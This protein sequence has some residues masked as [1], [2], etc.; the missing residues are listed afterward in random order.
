MPY[1]RSVGNAD[2]R[3]QNR[4]YRTQRNHWLNGVQSPIRSKGR[5][6]RDIRFGNIGIEYY[7]AGLLRSGNV[8]Y[9]GKQRCGTDGCRFQS[10]CSGRRCAGNGYP[11]RRH[12]KR[13]EA[14]AQ[15]RRGK[16]KNRSCAHCQSCAQKYRDMTQAGA[17]LSPRMRHDFIQYS[18]SPPGRNRTSILAL[19]E[20]CS[21][22]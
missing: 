10:R 12:G 11:N 17:K 4:P 15:A 13:R 20:R 6:R 5:K 16:D 2:F 18:I 7:A 22:H 14:S 19:E 21:I 8:E 3:Y 1:G 9:A